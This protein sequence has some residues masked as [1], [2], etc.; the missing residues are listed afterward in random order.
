MDKISKIIMSVG[1]LLKLGTAAIRAM[2]AIRGPDKV[3]LGSA[4]ETKALKTGKNDGTKIR[5][6][7]RKRR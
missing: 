6:Q 7:K 3:D 5:F 4:N 1:F 2:F